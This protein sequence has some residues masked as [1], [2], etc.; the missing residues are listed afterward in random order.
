MV[1]A[2][3]PAVLPPRPMFRRCP[4][5]ILYFSFQ[6]CLL[7]YLSLATPGTGRIHS[8]SKPVTRP[9]QTAPW[10]EGP[11]VDEVQRGRQPITSGRNPPDV[12]TRGRLRRTRV[13]PS[14]GGLETG[15]QGGE[16]DRATTT[17]HVRRSAR[18]RMRPDR[19]V[20]VRSPSPVFRLPP[21]GTCP[22]IEGMPATG[23]FWT[24][25]SSP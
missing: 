16:T 17:R 9:T 12:F 10:A 8:T 21:V 23:G 5:H 15:P 19:L 18:V 11:S 20:Q 7:P 3:A 25:G 6:R 22:G 24:T 1:T 2:R 14:P 13:T 4:P